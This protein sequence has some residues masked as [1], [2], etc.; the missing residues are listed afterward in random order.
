[1]LVGI[2]LIGALT[3]TIASYFAQERTFVGSGN[4]NGVGHFDGHV[5]TATATSESADQVT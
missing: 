5:E 2:G 1:M 4:S 3:A